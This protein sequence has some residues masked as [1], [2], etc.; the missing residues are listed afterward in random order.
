MK[1][2]STKLTVKGQITLKK[3]YRDLLGLKPNDVVYQKFENGRIILEKQPNF[4][5]LAGTLKPRKNIGVDPV[6]ARDYMEKHYE[7]I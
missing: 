4:L 5:D 1:S 7:R 6:D 2:G 3:E